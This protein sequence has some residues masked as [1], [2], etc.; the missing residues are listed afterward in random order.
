MNSRDCAS[1]YMGLW[2]MDGNTFTRMFRAWKAGELRAAEPR[3][4]SALDIYEVRDGTGYIS[5]NGVLMK[6]GSKFGGGSTVAMRQAFRAARRDDAVKRII[7]DMDSPG[8]TVAG[9]D[10]LAQDIYD[11]DK[12]KPVYAVVSDLAGSAA[13]WL[14]SQARHI[15]ATRSSRV[16][17]IGVYRVV[18][19]T[20]GEFAARGVKVH[21]IASARHKGAM[22]DGVEISDESLAIVQSE[23][24][25]LSE[26]FAKSVATG[27]RMAIDDV[28]KLATGQVWFADEAKANGLIDAV[29]SRDDAIR[30]AM[31]DSGTPQRD[32][33][34]RRMRMSAI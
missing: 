21:V 27:R 25:Q 28:R 2:A 3:Q 13:Y 34:G 26:L 23:V 30:R 33:A 6:A 12:V 7:F 8:G 29:E 31:K 14:A 19:D 16:G 9:T 11:T 1:N 20:S 17:S 24:D 5:A 15:S 4:S 10:D 32:N 22:E 18:E